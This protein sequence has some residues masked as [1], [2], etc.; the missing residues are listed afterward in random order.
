MD[1]LN[2][3]HF[4]TASVA[5]VTAAGSMGL[6]QL[7]AL[8]RIAPAPQ[9]TGDPAKNWKACHEKMK[10]SNLYGIFL[11][12][13]ADHQQAALC[14]PVIQSAFTS[15]DK[16]V[17][18]TLGQAMW[19]AVPDPH[20]RKTV[21]DLN[22][23]SNL[24]I[25]DWEGALVSETRLDYH[26]INTAKAFAT[27]AQSALYGKENANLKKW[28]VQTRTALEKSQCE[29][30]DQALVDLNATQVKTRRAAFK[31]LEDKLPNA[32][33]MIA[34][35]AA[36]TK[37]LEVRLTCRELL[38]AAQQNRKDKITGLSLT[39]SVHQ[40]QQGWGR[41]DPCPGCGLGYISGASNRFLNMFTGQ[42]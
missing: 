34:M 14:Y 27:F 18:Q 26:T 29:L 20:L 32:T 24:V 8:S 21:K 12:I 17:L 7:H 19:S 9:C 16:N 22:A 25:R 5:G 6:T 2:R 4:I 28:D 11:S 37:S 38:A 39:Q 41:G 15:S 33:A 3:R 31:A 10:A 13:P 30:I 36:H 35:T 40:F 23:Q 42:G 1:K